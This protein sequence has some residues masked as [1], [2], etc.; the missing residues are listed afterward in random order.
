[1]GFG[2]ELCFHDC[3]LCRLVGHVAGFQRSNCHGYRSVWC[4]TGCVCGELPNE[5]HAV[6]LNSNE[7][8]RKDHCTR[9]YGEYSHLHSSYL[10]NNRSKLPHNSQLLTLNS[11]NNLPLMLRSSELQIPNPL[12]RPR[13]QLP[14]S[15]RNRHARSYQSALNMCL[16]LISP[17]PNP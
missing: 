7:N 5:K 13:C 17:P 6:K 10:L 14:I 2:C 9:T 1:M 16:S 4:G 12:P 11:S 3:V 15:N 8:V